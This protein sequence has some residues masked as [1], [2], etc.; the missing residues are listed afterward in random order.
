MT[1]PRFCRI[2]LIE[3]DEIRIERVTGWMP[4]HMR[5]VV[6]RS[7][8]RAISTLR[9]DGPQTYAGVML[10]HDLQA[11]AIAPEE[12]A[13][14]GSTLLRLIVERIDHDVPI[15]V[16]SMNGAKGPAMAERLTNAGF[17]TSYVPFENLT[18][19]NFL[20]WLERVYDLWDGE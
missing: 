1:P 17:E 15:L 20:R 12:A 5:L 2:L 4:P 10:D 3:D 8:G 14:S 11:Q 19:E 9:L 7:P 6:A 13:L 16:H 18:H